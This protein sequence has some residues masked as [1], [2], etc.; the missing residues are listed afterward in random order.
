MMTNIETNLTV[1]N[2]LPKA[3]GLD[4]LRNPSIP[5]IILKLIWKY[6]AS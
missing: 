6:V 4:H 1:G 5:R 3:K 2:G